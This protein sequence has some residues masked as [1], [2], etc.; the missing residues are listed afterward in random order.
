MEVMAIEPANLPDVKPATGTYAELVQTYCNRIEHWKKEAT[1]MPGTGSPSYDM[2]QLNQK[3]K[4]AMLL[5]CEFNIVSG[6]HEIGQQYLQIGKNLFDIRAK[7][8]HYA[9]PMKDDSWI[10][11]WSFEEY[12]ED[13][14]GLKKSSAYALLGVYHEFATAKGELK[15]E[16]EGFSYSQ[17]VEMLPMEY[18]ERR[19]V[20]SDMTVKQ[21]RELRQGSAKKAVPPPTVEPVV[22]EPAEVFQTSGQASPVCNDEKSE[23]PIGFQT[24]GKVSDYEQPKAVRTSGQAEPVCNGSDSEPAEVFQTSGN[25][26]DSDETK[27]TYFKNDT[28][29]KAFLDSYRTWSQWLSVPELDFVVYRV[30][31]TDGATVLAIEYTERPIPDVHGECR[32][33]KFLLFAPEERLCLDF[34]TT[35][36]TYIVQ[37]LSKEKVGAYWK[38][39]D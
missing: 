32:A 27:I 24:S 20:T 21:I 4:A 1:T 19:K 7:N 25:D 10:Q 6:I 35:A 26:N 13:R 36:P 14:F 18:I 22:I 38:E 34:Y 8:L 17:L 16:Y 3:A 9:V 31:L 2:Y 37:Y 23:Q 39:P 29:R 5:Q 12:V 15:P 33:H 30:S 28:E 11:S